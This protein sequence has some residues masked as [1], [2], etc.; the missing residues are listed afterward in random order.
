MLGVYTLCETLRYERAT[1]ASFLAPFT[2]SLALLRGIQALA[3]PAPPLLR[4]S[5]LAPYIQASRTFLSEPPQA[6]NASASSSLA[7]GLGAGS[8]CSELLKKLLAANASAADTAGPAANSASVPD[9]QPKMYLE[10]ASRLQ[11]VFDAHR[12]FPPDTTLLSLVFA[13]PVFFLSAFLAALREERPESLVILAHYAV[14]LV[15]GRR[16]WLMGYSGAFVIESVGERLG[17][18]WADWLAVPLAALAQAK[19]RDGQ[20]VSA[21][22]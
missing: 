22:T 12:G 8:E 2:Q 13:W 10:T 6:D 3:D 7:E 1:L 20:S 5:E 18:A 14:L 4:D 15:R 17:P 21:P 9:S 19:G 16:L 11:R